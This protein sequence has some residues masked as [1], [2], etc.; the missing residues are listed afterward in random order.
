[1]DWFLGQVSIVLNTAWYEPK[2][3]SDPRDIEAA[4]Q[5]LQFR[6]GWFAHPIYVNGDY[7]DIMKQRNKMNL[8]K[9][10]VTM[11]LQNFTHEQKVKLY[12][13][14]FSYIIKFAFPSIV[15]GSVI[16]NHL[17]YSRCTMFAHFWCGV[18]YWLCS[19]D[20]L[21]FCEEIRRYC[22]LTNH[23]RTIF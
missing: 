19:I 5:A 14:S 20:N 15:Q 13:M 11:V 3:P 17:P 1:M 6:L 22:M 16:I 10:V 7:P 2:N 8:Q 12:G 9:N 23:E 18:L 21:K 4:E